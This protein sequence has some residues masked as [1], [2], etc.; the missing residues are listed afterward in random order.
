MMED[1]GSVCPQ[2]LLLLHELTP[3]NPLSTIS[4]TV[5]CAVFVKGLADRVTPKI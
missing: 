5:L 1:S 2:P 4:D 3:G